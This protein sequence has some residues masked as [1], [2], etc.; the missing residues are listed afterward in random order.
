MLKPLVDLGDVFVVEIG[1][2]NRARHASFADLVLAVDAEDVLA[3]CYHGLSADLQ[4]DGALKSVQKR[5]HLSRA[6]VK[7]LWGDQSLTW[8]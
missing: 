8:S 2:A 6:L 7:A 3:G 1:S 5:D 4:A